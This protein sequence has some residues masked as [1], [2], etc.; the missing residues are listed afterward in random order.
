MARRDGHVLVGSC[1]E[2]VGLVKGTTPEMLQQLSQWGE[3]ILPSLAE[4]TPVHSWSGLRPGTVDG[5]PILGPVPQFESI[6]VA[7]GHYR[8]GIHLLRRLQWQWPI[9]SKA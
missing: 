1:E 3:S 5:F 6:W 2:E 4:Q 7:A 8:S 9:V